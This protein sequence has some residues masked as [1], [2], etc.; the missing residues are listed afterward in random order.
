MAVSVA[1]G[2]SGT[3]KGRRWA[4][5][6]EVVPHLRTVRLLLRSTHDDGQAEAEAEVDNDEAIVTA[7]A[8]LLGK[9]GSEERVAVGVP[10]ANAAVR[11][12]CD[13]GAC[14]LPCIVRL[15]HVEVN[16]RMAQ[17]V[18]CSWQHRTVD[19]DQLFNSGD[20]VVSSPHLSRA[21]APPSA[22]WEELTGS[23]C[24][25]CCGKHAPST[26]H[27]DTVMA[28][29]QAA[30]SRAVV[31]AFAISLHN[32]DVRMR[33]RVDDQDRSNSCRKC[34]VVLG[35][36]RKTGPEVQLYKH[37]VTARIPGVEDDPESSEHWTLEGAFAM[38]LLEASAEQ[39]SHRFAIRDTGSARLLLQ[40]VVMNWK[41]VV[42]SI[43]IQGSQGVNGLFLAPAV[44]LLYK[45]LTSED[46]S[47]IR[48]GEKWAAMHRSEDIRL[49]AAAVSQLIACMRE[50]N[51]SLPPACRSFQGFLISHIRAGA[52]HKP[53]LL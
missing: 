52:R 12:D 39:Q 1:M 40:V 47:A 24:A 3:E 51:A 35:E 28:S 4:V 20:K 41:S 32:D 48:E 8:S 42:G 53:L 31:S 5:H 45:D 23:F 27:H 26:L 9:S 38:E 19:D 43:F 44:K 25:T 2:S 34:G 29:L 7:S 13:G 36:A 18:D 50:H 46:S 6:A 37:A 33:E 22:G 14:L 49:P 21:I 17:H 11:Q 30:P 16:L 10:V 15:D